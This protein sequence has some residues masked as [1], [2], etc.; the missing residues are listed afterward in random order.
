M[1]VP[2]ALIAFLPTYQNAGYLA[3]ALLLILKIIQGFAAG[4]EVP[5]SGYYISVNAAGANR[6]L[7]C[8]IA[9]ISGFLGMLLA[10]FVVFVLPYA[11]T[12]LTTL[13]PN[14]L[15]VSYA[16]ETWRWPF[17]LSIPLSLWILKIRASIPV[18]PTHSSSMRDRSYKP[19]APLL[20]TAVLVAFMELQI[21][22]LFI[23]LPSYLHTYL[24]I[25]TFEARATNVI[26]L[27][28]FCGV[29]L[30]AGYLTRW[31]AA[32][33]LTCVGITSS[34]LTSYPL[35]TLLQGASFAR[36][37]CVQFVFAL[38]AGCLVGV[39][40]IVLPDLLRNNWKTPGMTIAYSIPV[41]IFGGTA[42]VMCSY[43]IARTH[44]LTA[45]ALYLTGMALLA[46]PVAYR[47]AF[48]ENSV[49]LAEQAA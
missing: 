1:A 8:A 17:L 41:A 28:I 22:S 24:G 31:I 40:F 43:L 47:L 7:Y 16:G 18:A 25:A 23:W 39:C 37:L 36:L 21:Y 30:L 44:L 26:T 20:Q 10:A 15:I 6:G 11:A 49:S 19:I 29:M 32:T 3:T 45:P 2:A 33:Q 35:F 46:L 42:P 9:A 38:T 12:M 5:V 13:L 27:V 4:G 34:L 48:P 14:R